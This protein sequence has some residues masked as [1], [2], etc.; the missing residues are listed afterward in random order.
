MEYSMKIVIVA[1]CIAVS[2]PLYAGRRRV[3][4]PPPAALS[5]EFVNVPAAVTTI[6]AIGSDAWV[7][8]NTVSQQ[9]GS[10]GKSL[11]V[12][13]QFGIRILRAGGGSWGT[14]MV[15]ARLA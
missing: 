5:I 1:L 2:L 6:T 11:R 9:A 12:R 7:D 10:T 14:A 4:A 3:P 15:T 13:Q 8:V